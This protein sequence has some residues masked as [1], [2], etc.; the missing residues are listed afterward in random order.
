LYGRNADSDFNVGLKG[1]RK[2]FESSATVHISNHGGAR[3]DGYW[4][5]HRKGWRGVL[6]TTFY[7]RKYRRTDTSPFC[8]GPRYKVRAEK[9]FGGF[10][11]GHAVSGRGY[12]GH[13]N[14]KRA[15]TAFG[16]RQRW[17]ADKQQAVRIGGAIDL[18]GVVSAHGESGYS[19]N[20][21]FKQSFG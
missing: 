20:A 17:E 15:A 10:D 16:R 5:N 18:F 11:N 13:C 12:D 3:V 2:W 8:R 14:H 9:W 19:K 6:T 7:Q 1:S 21:Q 4:S